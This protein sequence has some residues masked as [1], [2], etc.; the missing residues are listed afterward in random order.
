[1]NCYKTPT[2]QE[3]MYKKLGSKKSAPGPCLVFLPTGRFFSA[4]AFVFFS[5][6]KTYNPARRSTDAQFLCSRCGGK[7]FT[8]QGRSN[9][10]CKRGV[11]KKGILK[12]PQISPLRSPSDEPGQSCARRSLRKNSKNTRSAPFHLPAFASPSRPPTASS[13]C[14]AQSGP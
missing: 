12:V 8:T 5:E 2:E 1:M 4:V 7:F 11:P 13:K 10:R 9:H 14:P 6:M 3:F